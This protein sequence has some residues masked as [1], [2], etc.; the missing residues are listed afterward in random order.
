M[1][2][3]L[4]AKM[5]AI[6]KK[7]PTDFEPYGQRSRDDALGQD[8]SC[9]CAH[10]ARLVEP[11]S[12]EESMDWGVCLHAASPRAGLL[13][14]EHQGCPEYQ[15]VDDK[16]VPKW[17]VVCGKE[18]VIRMPQGFCCGDCCLEKGAC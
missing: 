7:L 12:G 16:A 10:Y 14:F 15:H 3:R 18:A 13:T 6:A 1:P 9:N 11:L 4:H 8:C 5:W 17:C 2:S